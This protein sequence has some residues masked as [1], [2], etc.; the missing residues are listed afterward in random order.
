MIIP[1]LQMRKVSQVTEGVNG[2]TG[3][4]TEVFLTPKQAE[5]PKT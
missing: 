1:V 4:G 3:S 2:Q 5:R